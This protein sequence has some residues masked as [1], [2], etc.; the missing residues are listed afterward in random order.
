MSVDH[1]AKDPKEQARVAAAGGKIVNDRL[2]HCMEVTRAFGDLALA[3]HGMWDQP[4]ISITEICDGRDT[5]VVLCSDGLTDFLANDEVAGVVTANSEAQARQGTRKLRSLPAASHRAG[6]GVTTRRSVFSDTFFKAPPSQGG[7]CQA[8]QGDGDDSDLDSKPEAPPSRRAH[9]NADAKEK[10]GA[11][12]SVKLAVPGGKHRGRASRS[13][14]GLSDMSPPSKSVP[15][16]PF[17]SFE[18]PTLA[19]EPVPLPGSGLAQYENEATAGVAANGQGQEKGEEHHTPRTPPGQETRVRLSV[20]APRPSRPPQLLTTFLDRGKQAD[21]AEAAAAKK[22]K[23]GLDAL[24]RRW[25][26]GAGGA[27][28]KKAKAREARRKVKQRPSNVSK[29]SSSQDGQE[30]ETTDADGD[31]VTCMFAAEHMLKVRGCD[32]WFG[33]A[34]CDCAHVTK[35]QTPDDHVTLYCTGRCGTKMHR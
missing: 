9:D 25:G 14:G 8:T 32:D 11:A 33:F 2:A 20:T 26:A 12:M 35:Q 31:G 18:P 5:H 6:P 15:S 13:V 34:A 1:R 21:R 29:S 30:G 10:R 19:E 16:T 3:A 7:H 27:A 23:E 24:A 22:K 17:V 4:D 28:A